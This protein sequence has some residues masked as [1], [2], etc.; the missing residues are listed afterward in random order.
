[1][2]SSVVMTRLRVDPGRADRGVFG[3]LELNQVFPFG[4]CLPFALSA[5]LG[6]GMGSPF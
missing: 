6:G 2:P 4:L 1:M 5:M 3:T